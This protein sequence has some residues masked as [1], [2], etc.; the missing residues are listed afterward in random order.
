LG[1]RYGA[2][3]AI[4]DDGGRLSGIVSAGDLRRAI[5]HGQIRTAPLKEV[6]NSAPVTITRAELESE[7]SVNGALADLKALYATEQ[8]HVMVP[9]VDADR[10][11][12]GVIDVQSLL[13]RAPGND[14]SP[15]RRTVLVVGGAGYIGSVLV[16]KLLA[17]GWA[18]R[19]LDLFLYGRR[20][21]EGLHAEIDIVEGDAKNIDTLVKAVEGV[22]AVVYLAELVG[23]PAVAQ[24]P[25][26][27][28]KTNYLAVTALAQLCEYLNINR[29]VYTS[30]CSVYGA[31]ANPNE[32]LTEQSATAP[33]SLYGKIKLMVEDAV[34]SMARQPNQLFAPT[35]LRL[36]TVYGCSPR[37]R[38]DLVVNTLTK[39]AAT[40][41]AIDLFGGEQ[42]RPHVHVGDVARAIVTVLDA[43]LDLVRAEVFNV[44]D[45]DQNYT[46][47]AIG[48]LVAE[49][50]PEMTVNRLNTSVDARNYRVNCAKLHDTLDYQ[51]ETTVAD[52]V[53]ELKA[54]LESGD[55]GD[56]DQ[57]GYS[58]L[59][60]VQDLAFD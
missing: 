12:L 38:F 18:V 31:S 51:I 54:A 33:V 21:L 36:G 1:D 26:T 11:P 58:N 39:H 14:F 27:A 22:D 50:F 32:F 10:R 17:D 6:M 57:P 44:G 59:Q 34:L 55:L 13:M 35:I 53:R 56:L 30:S 19:V 37:A 52:G 16:R 49:Q 3:V 9:V 2:I 29:F 28:L 4:V 15:H 43:P 60:T 42:W 7:E 41:G 47:N 8:M 46:I 45:S 25:Q 5:L 40:R 24:A 23:D 20:S 48:D